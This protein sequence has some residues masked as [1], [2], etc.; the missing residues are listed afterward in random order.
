[1]VMTTQL[2]R[3]GY[4][5]RLHPGRLEERG[6]TRERAPK[7]LPS[8]SHAIRHGRPVSETA[9]EILAKGA[10]RRTHDTIE[11]AEAHA[12][13]IRRA[14]ELGLTRTMTP[15]EQRERI[16]AA[17]QQRVTQTPKRDL[18]KHYE[19]LTAEA[20]SL[21]QLAAALKIEHALEQRYTAMRKPRPVAGVQRM[22][23]LLA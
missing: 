6:F 17:R 12:Y 8:E 5:A 4:R 18:R 16:K 19:Q 22:E 3:H 7:L 20:K 10:E 2:A 14:Q 11:L 1:D 21:V 15:T 13:W 9:Q 23:R